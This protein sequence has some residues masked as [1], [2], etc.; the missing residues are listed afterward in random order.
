ML[1]QNN[2]LDPHVLGSENLQRTLTS[3]SKTKLEFALVSEKQILEKKMN[4]PNLSTNW[5]MALQA[6]VSRVT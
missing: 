6:T 4:S 5:N 3:W 1:K 2:E